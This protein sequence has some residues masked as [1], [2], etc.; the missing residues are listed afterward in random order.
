M[1]RSKLTFTVVLCETDCKCLSYVLEVVKEHEKHALTILKPS[2]QLKFDEYLGL[3]AN[4]RWILK[5]DEKGVIIVNLYELKKLYEMLDNIRS[6]IKVG[7]SSTHANF[8]YALDLC[9]NS[10]FELFDNLLNPLES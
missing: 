1:E 4:I 9:Y 8:W 6:F 5:K 3:I 10:V 2:S 7:T